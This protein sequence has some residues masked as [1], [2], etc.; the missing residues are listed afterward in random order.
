MFVRTR[1]AQSGQPSR[2]CLPYW[3]NRRVLPVGVIL[4][5]CV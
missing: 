3:C 4:R 1:R 5:A 2:D